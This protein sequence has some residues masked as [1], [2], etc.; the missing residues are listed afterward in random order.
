MFLG[1]L[2]F[3]LIVL[4]AAGLKGHSLDVL[5]PFY[6][7]TSRTCLSPPQPFCAAN[8]RAHMLVYTDREQW[9]LVLLFPQADVC[10]VDSTRGRG[11][12]APN[13]AV[14]ILIMYIEMFLS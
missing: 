3:F 12:R 8:A 9:S 4:F 2:Q 6:L 7:G 11:K 1:F 10:V 14:A 13:C 5:L